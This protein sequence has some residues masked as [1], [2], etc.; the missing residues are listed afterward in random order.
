[1]IPVSDDDAR[2]RLNADGAALLGD[3]T[4]QVAEL[5][6]PMMPERFGFVVVVA[7]ASQPD[8]L[9]AYSGN[10]TKP[11]MVGLLSELLRGTRAEG[12]H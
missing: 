6:A 5:I 1:L 7:D 11:A 12:G 3:L 9:V 8:G 4:K 10:I 2:A